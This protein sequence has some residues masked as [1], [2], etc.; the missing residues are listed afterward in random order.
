MGDYGVAIDKEKLVVNM[1][2]LFRLKEQEADMYAGYVNKIPTEFW[3]EEGCMQFSKLLQATFSGIDASLTLTYPALF[4]EKE[5]KKQLSAG[6]LRNQ[7][8]LKLVPAA[9]FAVLNNPRSFTGVL[10]E[11]EQLAEGKEYSAALKAVLGE[12]EQ[13][14]KPVHS[15]RY[16]APGSLSSAQQKAIINAIEYPV[17]LVVGPPGTGKSYTISNLAIDQLAQGKTVLIASKTDT[18]VDVIHHKIEEILDELLVSVRAGQRGYKQKIRAHFSNLLSGANRYHTLEKELNPFHWSK[19]LDAT[20]KELEQLMGELP[21]QLAKASK[22]GATL[23]KANAHSEVLSWFRKRLIRWEESRTPPVWIKGARLEELTE[24]RAVYARKYIQGRFLYHLLYTLR[25]HRK[26]VARFDKALRSRIS[27]NKEKLFS[28]V[29]LQAVLDA[30]P[31]WLVN[32]NDVSQVLPMEKELFD[33][34][35]IDEATQCDISSCLPILQRA[36]KVVIV[37]DPKQLRHVSFLSRT[38][39]RQLL[40]KYGMEEQENDLFNYRDNSILD[41]VSSKLV[42]QEQLS[43]LN[44]HFRSS[45]AIIRF[46]NEQFYNSSLSIMKELPHHEQ[47]SLIFKEVNGRRCEKGF[48]EEEVRELMAEVRAILASEES[49]NASLCKKIGILSPFRDQA[50]FLAKRLEEEIPLEKLQKHQLLVGTA[51]S[52][53]GEER[54]VM[55]LSFALDDESHHSAFRHLEKHDVFNVTIT[56]ARSVQQVFYSFNAQTLPGQSLVKQYI[57]NR[58]A[59]QKNQPTEPGSK[60]FGK[61]VEAFIR[62]QGYTYWRGYVLMGEELDFLVKVGDSYIGLDLIGFPDEQAKDIPLEKYQAFSRAGLRVFPLPYVS[63]Y[64]R[65]EE[66]R[67]AI[68]NLAR[69]E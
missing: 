34:A 30:L 33:L 18:A 43:F 67:Q 17:S 39:Q 59:V 26:D 51:Y 21:Q 68:L 20:D 64:F 16:V 60:T 62:E 13:L 58:I 19:L 38:A 22:R 25:K 14:R 46:S 7:E 61:E 27:G 53:Q 48:N 40:L 41:L 56:R 24:K 23:S 50:D 66:T 5:V 31:V 55:L 44:E 49:V 12:D 69:L 8:D 3:T 6:K 15:H 32:L 63:W 54:D 57:G 42:S 37:G 4:G 2:D 52:F 29:R 65:R 11:L 47:E 10:D 35:I 36:K 9:F 28:Q 45:P 1:R